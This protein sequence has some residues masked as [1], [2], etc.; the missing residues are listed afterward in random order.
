MSAWGEFAFILATASFEE[1]T[2]DMEA[3]S[4]V[5]L[6][7]MVSVIVSPYALRLTVN[8]YAKRQM[9]KL[10]KHLTKYG[11]DDGLLILYCNILLY[12]NMFIL[13][14]HPVY[15]A[16]ITKARGSWGHQDKLLHIIFEHKL[17]IIDFRAW[18]APEYNYSHHKP[19]TKESFYVQDLELIL[20]PTKYL[21]KDDKKSLHD[22]VK[23]IREAMKK[24]LGNEATVVV[25]RWLPGLKKCDDKKGMTTQDIMRARRASYCR[26]EAFKQAHSIMSYANI[27]EV[28]T[29]ELNEERKQFARM[30]GTKAV[31]VNGQ[32]ELLTELKKGRRPSSPK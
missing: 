12:K 20:P 11:T 27:T 31:T 28:I 22:R 6:A 25:K 3:F 7:V 15:Y 23:S 4:S 29:Q 13:I 10:D 2:I 24:V 14:G 1:G 5:L 19:L 9:K 32:T 30:N 21:N 17:S 26:R 18:H 16:I 8:H